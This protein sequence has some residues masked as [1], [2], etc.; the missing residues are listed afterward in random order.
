MGRKWSLWL[1]WKIKATFGSRERSKTEDHLNS[2]VYK[3]FVRLQETFCSFLLIS[4]LAFVLNV[5]FPSY[6]SLL[7]LN[8]G[9][10]CFPC[11]S[12]WLLMSWLRWDIENLLEVKNFPRDKVV[13]TVCQN[14]FEK[15]HWNKQMIASSYSNASLKCIPVNIHSRRQNKTETKLHTTPYQKII[16]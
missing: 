10:V 3:R 16:L 13:E 7:L 4:V 6:F 14:K 11:C 15:S 5:I 1:Y 8:F 12:C 2:I 9:I